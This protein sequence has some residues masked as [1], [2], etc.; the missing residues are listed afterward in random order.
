MLVLIINRQSCNE[1]LDVC[2]PAS[3]CSNKT[4]FT[5]GSG[6]LNVRFDLDTLNETSECH[7]LEICCEPEN[8]ISE[9]EGQTTIVKLINQN[10]VD[11]C[12]QQC[13]A[14]EPR[15]TPIR[16]P[17]IVDSD[18]R[19][20]I[21]QTCGLRNK[22]GVGMEIINN[23]DV[24]QFGEFPWMLGI[25]NSSH[26]YICGGSLIHSQVVLTAAHCVFDKE[27]KDLIIRAGEWVN[28]A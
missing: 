1:N 15:V 24:A 10:S 5:D 7:Y 16:P 25:L 26:Y 18:T 4:V 23:T 27:A 19:K 17:Q 22:R 2:V 9:V 21:T 28:F 3:L 12:I 8:V 6:S 20:V 11:A 14:V 13:Q